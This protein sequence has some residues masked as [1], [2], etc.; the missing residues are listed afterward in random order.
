MENE[1]TNKTCQ[2][3]EMC[4]FHYTASLSL[5]LCISVSLS[6]S[7]SVSVWG[8]VGGGGNEMLIS[9]GLYKRSGL[10]RNKTP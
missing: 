10:V 9:V 3:V 4:H 7:V 6:V 2:W 8:E 1:K 5:S